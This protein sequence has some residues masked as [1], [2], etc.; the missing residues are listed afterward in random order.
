MHRHL[1]DCPFVK[2]LL[3]NEWKTDD[4]L[5]INQT[6]N[7]L[8]MNETEMVITEQGIYLDIIY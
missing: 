2:I 4:D 3:Q 5:S 1:K 8:L 6:S 7:I